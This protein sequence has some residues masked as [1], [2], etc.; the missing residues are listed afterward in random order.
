[1]LEETLDAM[2][3]NFDYVADA[4]GR[5]AVAMGAGA[6]L[7][8]VSYFLLSSGWKADH[9]GSSA[10]FRKIRWRIQWVETSQKC[11][12]LC[13]WKVNIFL[14]VLGEIQASRDEAGGAE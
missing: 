13:W 11:D 7:T 4:R 3:R 10:M 9:V 2:W 8:T 12:D 6:L 1:M 14:D 5:K